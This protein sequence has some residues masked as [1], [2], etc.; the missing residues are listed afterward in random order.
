MLNNKKDTPYSIP[1][2]IWYLEVT[3]LLLPLRSQLCAKPL[4]TNVSCVF[5]SR[6]IHPSIPSVAKSGAV[7]M[8]SASHSFAFTSLYPFFVDVAIDALE[9]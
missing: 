1:N 2:A 7:V 9:V 8:V 3:Q 6:L 4:E 5:T